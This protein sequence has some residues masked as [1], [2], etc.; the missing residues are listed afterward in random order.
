MQQHK[1][2]LSKEKRYQN[3]FQGFLLYFFRT[4]CDTL[5]FKSL[6]PLKSPELGIK[7]SKYCDA[8]TGHSDPSWYTQARIQTGVSKNSYCSQRASASVKRTKRLYRWITMT[9][10]SWP[11]KMKTAMMDFVKN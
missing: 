11:R 6:L 4:S 9:Q 7:A 8:T 10:P 1:W 3:L 2:A 5:F